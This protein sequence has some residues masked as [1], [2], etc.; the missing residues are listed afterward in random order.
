MARP[1]PHSSDDDDDDLV[2]D[3]GAD[4][5]D[6]PRLLEA[7]AEWFKLQADTSP[8]YEHQTAVARASSRL[9]AVRAELLAHKGDHDASR[10][11]AST[12]N[13][14]AQLAVK[15]DMSA[16]VDRVT[17]LELALRQARSDATELATL[18]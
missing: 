16:V 10:K 14:C 7:Q 2:I 1:R 15:L 4:I 8:S 17:A 18:K 12:S 5:A 13:E 9:W 3:D 6:D 11:A